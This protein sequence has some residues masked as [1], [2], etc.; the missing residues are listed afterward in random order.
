MSDL[1][2][3]FEGLLTELAGARPDDLRPR[4]VLADLLTE[5]GHPWGELIQLS[6]EAT[7]T[8]RLLE[9]LGEH[10]APFCQLVAPGAMAAWVNQGLPEIAWYESDDL[11]AVSAPPFPLLRQVFVRVRRGHGAKVLA[12]PLLRQV[13]SLHLAADHEDEA[14]D[15]APLLSL[16]SLTVK[17]FRGKGFG[18]LLQGLP[19][20]R[21][22]RLEC[23][24]A[25][26]ASE[27]LEALGL[28]H[29]RLDVLEVDSEVFDRNDV[30]PV[31]RLCGVKQL[32]V[33][34]LYVPAFDIDDELVP[35]RQVVAKDPPFTA[36][37][38]GGEL[39]VRVEPGVES[40]ECAPSWVA[41]QR[42]RA[43]RSNPVFV[44]S[45]FTFLDGAPA[46]VDEQPEGNTL[47][48][49]SPGLCKELLS[50]FSTLARASGEA[51]PFEFTRG[52]VMVAPDTRVLSYWNTLSPR[53]QF[54][55]HALL[56]AESIRGMPST[57][58]SSIFSL[59]VLLFEAVT[60]HLPHL[61]GDS[62]M[63]V[64]K[65]TLDN[66]F[67]PLSKHLEVPAALETLMTQ[68]LRAE[69][70]E[71]PSALDLATRLDALAVDAPQDPYFTSVHGPRKQHS[72]LIGLNPFLLSQRT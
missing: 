72:F 12:H 36:T 10:E 69:P 45:R 18:A 26:S 30:M 34:R 16:E 27:S 7:M 5:R 55:R 2:T 58:A 63:G 29:P 53:T 3:T 71:R 61:H 24:R 6:A 32:D 23:R 46:V 15:S 9:L 70:T 40:L 51:L 47:N 28:A 42:V 62:E 13:T 57:P 65:S 22:L 31:A 64:L 56:S 37:L 60:G 21:R 1:R 52:S 11:L 33:R 59:G 4:L 68:L 39:E 41:E 38:E 44:R 17:G 66:R 48:A 43:A 54:H 19:R 20:L 35:A 25:S 14:L 67:A 50:A 8:P 49:R